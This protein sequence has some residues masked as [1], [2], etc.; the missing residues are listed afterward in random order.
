MLKSKSCGWT[1]ETVELGTVK[2]LEQ[3]LLQMI[4]FS[5]IIFSNFKFYHL[6]TATGN[7]SHSAFTYK[8]PISLRPGKNEIA[9]LSLTVGLQV[10]YL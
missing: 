7:G 4:S 5:P 3:Q 2:K 10:R 6:G 1:L 8:N 9:L